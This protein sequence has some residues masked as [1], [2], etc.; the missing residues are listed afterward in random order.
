MASDAT[1]PTPTPAPAPAPTPAPA[2][3]PA[4]TPTP[5]ADPPL[6]SLFS[7]LGQKDLM[8][9][10]VLVFVINI[11]LLHYLVR[12]VLMAQPTTAE[13][14]FHDDFQRADVG[15]NYWSTGGHWRIE[16]GEVHAPGV[17]NNPLWL[18]VALPRD[19]AVEFDVRSQ[20]PEGDI[21]FELFGD[22]ENHS[23]GY[24]FI[25]GGWNNQIS[26]VSR[27]N[28]HGVSFDAMGNGMQ[29]QTPQQ[30]VVAG[31]SLSEMYST[32]YFGAKA[33]WRVER[34]DIRVTIG[35]RYHMRIEARGNDL[36]WFIDGQPVFRITDPY[37]FGGKHHDRLGL[38]SWDSDL[39]FDNIDIKPL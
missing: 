33:E 3:A 26:T 34:R 24:C 1:A 31:R 38:S 25:F 4:A 28:E 30:Q 32:G 7:D 23:S 14:P 21:K 36:A 15:P 20:S 39:Y 35:Q 13:V 19:V 22:G 11:P 5:P 37:R 29:G 6:F 8:R 27:L 16:N 10:G 12:H 2:P 9:L 17:K 18:Q